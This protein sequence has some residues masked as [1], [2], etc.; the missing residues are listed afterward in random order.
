[1]KERGDLDEIHEKHIQEHIEFNKNIE[2]MIT[3][4]FKKKN[5]ITKVFKYLILSV[6]NLNERI[7][8]QQHISN[9]C[10]MILGFHHR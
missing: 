3:I 2:F 7:N 8:L 10:M 4:I 6:K 9:I 5:L 1:M